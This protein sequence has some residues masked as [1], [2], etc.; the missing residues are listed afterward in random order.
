MRDAV[1]LGLAML[2][3]LAA[4]G[5]GQLEVNNA[6]KH[7]LGPKASFTLECPS[8]ELR[9]TCLSRGSVRIDGLYY[10]GVCLSYGVKGCSSRAQ[11]VYVE[12]HGWV[13]DAH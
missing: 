7:D 10:D 4:C 5:G 2:F 3:A 6:M 8:G 12:D 1:C 11:F 9:L 13:T